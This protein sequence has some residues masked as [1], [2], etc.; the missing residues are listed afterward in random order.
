MRLQFFERL[1]NV[2]D[3]QSLLA[4]KKFLSTKRILSWGHFEL[5]FEWRL[6]LEY[7]AQ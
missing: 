5:L 2:L 4:C 7:N 6:S 1:E 3:H